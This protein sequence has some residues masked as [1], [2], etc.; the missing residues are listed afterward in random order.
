M[1]EGNYQ[2]AIDLNRNVV[3]KN[4]GAGRLWA[5]FIQIVHQYSSIHYLFIL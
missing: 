3:M 2:D 1:K 4:K 5:S